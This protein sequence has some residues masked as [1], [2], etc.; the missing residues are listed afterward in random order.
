[1]GKYQPYPVKTFEQVNYCIPATCS[2]PFYLFTNTLISDRLSTFRTSVLFSNTDI[3]FSSDS[4][5]RRYLKKHV[6]S[7][8]KQHGDGLKNLEANTLLYGNQM[9]KTI[10]NYKGN[11]IRMTLAHIMLV[12]LF[13]HSSDEDAAAFIEDQHNMEE[14]MKPSGP[15]ILLD[16]APFLR[17]FMSPVKR[18]YTELINFVT[19]TNLLY[20]NYIEGRRKFYNHP[21]IEFFI[22]YFFNLKIMNQTE[23]TTFKI[24]D[25]MIDIGRTPGNSIRADGL[26]MGRLCPRTILSNK[27]L[28]HLGLGEGNALPKYLPE[29]GFSS[30][31]PCY[32][33]NSNSLQLKV[34]RDQI[35]TLLNAK[36]NFLWC[37]S[38]INCL[39]NPG[40]NVVIPPQLITYSVLISNCFALNPYGKQ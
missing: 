7:A 35:M 38:H 10:G 30:W 9:I 5:K 37:K 28:S 8:L 36:L 18:A 15:Y 20:D 6:M 14:L 3:G 40:T 31:R 13:G 22:D 26:K 2:T 4:P 12:L 34:I 11:L 21:N 32:C 39:S 29:I 17:Y 33:K 19:T 25:M 16:V 24:D 27:G 23:D 1:M